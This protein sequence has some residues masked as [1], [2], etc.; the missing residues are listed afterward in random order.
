[1]SDSLLPQTIQSMGFSRPE[2]WSGQPFPSPG[3]LPD[4]GI[5]PRSPALQA[6]SLPAEP[7]GK[8]KNTGVGILSHFQGI[9]P[10]QEMNWGLPH[11]RRILYQLS[12]QGS[13]FILTIP[14]AAAAGSLCRASLLTLNT[15]HR[16]T[17][18]YSKFPPAPDL[19][20]PGLVP[21][22][23]RLEQPPAVAGVCPRDF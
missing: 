15:Q 11:C 12:R 18:H 1:M 2:H 6:D 19:L 8:P 4:P 23:S 17:Y 9:F 16:V 22:P 5:K 21:V 14:I 13:V 20:Q 7:P 3:D 10:T